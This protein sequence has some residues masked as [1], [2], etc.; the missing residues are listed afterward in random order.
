MTA[1]V[2]GYCPTCRS[3]WIRNRYGAKW[4][5]RQ[6]GARFPEPLPV[7]E[8]VDVQ[9]SLDRYP[10][11]SAF[12]G[13]QEGQQALA[14]AAEHAMRPAVAGQ[15]WAILFA[16][17]KHM[18]AVP[19]VPRVGAPVASGRGLSG[20]LPALFGDGRTVPRGADYNGRMNFHKKGK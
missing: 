19:V 14:F 20:H 11:E 15:A 7:I 5:C 13:T 1:P 18:P 3:G 6:C 12:W 2:S 17:R 16:I 10:A 9:R 8:R 4:D